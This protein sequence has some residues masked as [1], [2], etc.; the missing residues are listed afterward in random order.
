MHGLLG[1]ALAVVAAA[2]QPVA[3]SEDAGDAPHVVQ[4]TDVVFD[5]G[6]KKAFGLTAPRCGQHMPTEP[7]VKFELK[8][9]MPNG[10]T[11]A[12]DGGDNAG[13][14][15]KLGDSLWTTCAGSVGT[16]PSRTAPNEGW[17][18]GTYEVYPLASSKL[19]GGQRFAVEFYNPENPKTV[20]PDTQ[21]VSIPGKLEKPMFVEVALEP[22]RVKLRKLHSGSGCEDVALPTTPGLTLTLERPVPGLVVRPLPSAKP[23]T[24]RIQSKRG[25][26]CSSYRREVVPSGY[27]PSWES[28]SEFHGA[29]DEAGPVAISL[30]TADAS[31]TSKIT[32]MIFGESTRWDPLALH[33]TPPAD[34]PLAQRVLSRHYPQLDVREPGV[35]ERHEQLLLNAKLFSSVPKGLFVYSK[36]DLDKDLAQSHSPRARGDAFPVK[37]EAMLLLSWSEGESMVLT[38]DGLR[39]KVKSTALVE[40]P[41]GTAV[42]PSSPRPLGGEVHYTDAL[43]LTPPSAKGIA[44]AYD[45]REKKYIACA[46]K[47]W[48]P[49]GKQ[50]QGASWTIDGEAG[51]RSRI[52]TPRAKK[53][54]AAGAA[55]IAKKCG[56]NEA[57]QKDRETTRKKLLAAVE[58]ERA[59]VLSDAN[60]AL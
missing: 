42:L 10:F 6:Y 27:A 60:P 51:D 28:P 49:F 38:A 31:D 47:V 16:V 12:V 40:A 5:T 23:V 20:G 56:T 11:V 50:V 2:G 8:K 54:R 30:G 35:V 26:Y 46:D 1:A 3:I 41:E 34:L 17:V 24:M 39:F 21:Q 19:R 15:I 4:V 58:A 52:E 48:A 59:K 43:N 25:K 57:R 7:I 55:A 37:N 45:A 9:A 53:I 29:K 14:A 44:D 22:N 36:M 18:A 32:L 13:F 33:G